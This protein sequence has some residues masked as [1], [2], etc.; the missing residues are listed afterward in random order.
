MY[1]NSMI[2]LA[3]DWFT[4]MQARTSEAQ[5][6]RKDE[7]ICTKF[8]RN[9]YRWKPA[10]RSLRTLKRSSIWVAGMIYSPF[11]QKIGCELIKCLTE[12]RYFRVV[13]G[14]LKRSFKEA[15]SKNLLCRFIIFRLLKH[16]DRFIT[17]FQKGNSII[18]CQNN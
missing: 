9:S 14:C 3:F 11:S 17:K 8:P 5:E 10:K 1:Q 4:F 16:K 18:L 6:G 15:V 2:L 7:G 12:Q 13:W